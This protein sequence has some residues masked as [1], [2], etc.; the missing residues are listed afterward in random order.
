MSREPQRLV[1]VLNRG[2]FAVTVK[3]FS[4]PGLETAGY[5]FVLARTKRPP[6]VTAHTGAKM[7]VLRL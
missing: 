5:E 7:R 4:S 6:K 2:T 3:G 1:D